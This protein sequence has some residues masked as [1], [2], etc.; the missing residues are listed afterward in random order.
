MIFQEWGL[1]FFKKVQTA[2]SRLKLIELRSNTGIPTKIDKNS[3]F[4]LCFTKLKQFQALF[5]NNSDLN[6]ITIA[7][8]VI[9][10]F[11]I[12]IFLK[13]L[14]FVRKKLNVSIL[15][16]NSVKKNSRKPQVISIASFPTFVSTFR[17]EQNSTNN[18]KSSK[19]HP[20]E[21]SDSNIPL[22]K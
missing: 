14:S 20:I 18:L 22:L 17:A 2:E 16:R 6:R 15:A 5:Y 12:Y 10:G 19:F 21:I 9:Q 13:I 8:N 7:R 1:K 4:R 11:G 3:T